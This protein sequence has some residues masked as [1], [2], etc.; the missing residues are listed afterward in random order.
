ME[1][2]SEVVEL[3]ENQADNTTESPLDFDKI[4]KFEIGECGPYQILVA[5]IIGLV[6]TFAS[7]LIL[8]FVFITAIPDHRLI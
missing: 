3:S 7:F 4:L 5:A 8:N 2:F 1:Q 6:T